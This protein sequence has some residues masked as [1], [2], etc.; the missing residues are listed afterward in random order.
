MRQSYVMAVVSPEERSAVRGSQASHEPSVDPYPLVR[1]YDIRPAVADQPAILFAG[2][3]K[4]VYDLLLFGEFVA[5]RPP[6][7]NS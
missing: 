2:A 1:R 6:E 7:E 5:I 4:I 3:L